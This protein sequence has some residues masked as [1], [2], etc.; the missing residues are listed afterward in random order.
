MP[1]PPAAARK[2]RYHHG[3][4]PAA[5]LDA[6]ESIVAEQGV[7]AVSLRA[8]ARQVGVSHAAPAHHFGDLHGLLV[9]FARRGHQRF[10]DALQ[11]ARQEAGDAPLPQRLVAVGWAYFHFAVANP[12]VFSIM[13][14]DDLEADV[15]G[16][17]V[18]PP[19][20]AFGILRSLV[21]E[22][23]GGVDPEGPEV[24]RM[25]MCTW[26]Q[27]HG[28]VVLWLQGAPRSMA[29]LAADDYH[30]AML[31]AALRALQA[32]PAWAG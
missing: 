10:H 14:R 18:E 30:Q 3:D 23:L 8:A 13:F 24:T 1:T 4:L 15:F 2:D 17:E 16:P 6:V 5:L 27:V 9:A 20:D 21:A 31:D 11:E 26:A 12:G 29:G 28:A 32:D 25:A 19:P 22:G 7:A